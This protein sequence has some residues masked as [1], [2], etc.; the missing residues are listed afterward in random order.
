MNTRNLQ[1]I[2]ANY[3]DRFEEMNDAEHDETFKWWAAYQFHDLMDKALQAPTN[4][5]ADLLDAI[6]G[7]R[8]ADRVVETIIDGQMHPFAGLVHLAKEYNAEAVKTLFQNL[9]ADD[10]GDLN[11]REQKISVFL[12]GCEELRLAKFPNYYSYKQTARSVA[13]YLFLY[14]PE[15]YYMY[16]SKEAYRFAD[17]IEFNGDW[18]SGDH[19][20]L[21][22]Y[23]RMCDELVAEIKK[24]P[25]L[26]ATHN[27]RFSLKDRY[28]PPKLA[29]DSSYH[30]LAYDIIY[31]TCAYD[32]DRNITFKKI[33]L[34][35]K[36]LYQERLK[37]ALEVQEEYLQAEARYSELEPAIRHYDTLLVPETEVCH[38][39]YGTGKITSRK[40]KD[41][42][43]DF[44]NGPHNFQLDFFTTIA[45]SY[46]KFNDSLDCKTKESYCTLLKNHSNLSASMERVRSELKKY[47]DILE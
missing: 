27:S 19:L 13:G 3:I 24:C 39:T 32:L 29:N 22:E 2:F 7:H 46:L 34:Q 1:Q 26:C 17:D 40:G 41:I 37:K 33:S 38:V 4:Q 42:I 8:K 5:F 11:K 23:Y 25:A 20:K 35:E 15:Q 43:V 36:K 14:D 9:F 31:C 47:S 16:K 18:G 30:I 44:A 45:N 28:T 6:K 12:Q 21:K 10:G